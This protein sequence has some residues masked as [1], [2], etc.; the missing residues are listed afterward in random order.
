MIAR[1]F[2]VTRHDQPPEEYEGPDP[3]P[4]KPPIGFSR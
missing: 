3:E 2:R 4:P 1:V